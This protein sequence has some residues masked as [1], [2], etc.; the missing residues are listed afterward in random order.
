MI[1]KIK[2]AEKDCYWRHITYNY[3]NQSFRLFGHVKYENAIAN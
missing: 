3:A 1:I 2:S